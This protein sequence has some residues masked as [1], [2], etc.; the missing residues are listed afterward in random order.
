[1]LSQSVKIDVPLENGTKWEKVYSKDD[2]I[3]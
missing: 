3:Q 2:K 1:M